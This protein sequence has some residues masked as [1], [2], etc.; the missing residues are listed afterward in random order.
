MRKA[1]I[2]DG[3]VINVVEVDPDHVP[4]WCRD[5]P[6][7]DQNAAP[8]ATYER[9]RFT[10]SGNPS[11]SRPLARSEAKLSRAE[12][13]VRVKRAGIL[14][15]AQAKAAARG[16]LPEPFR[17]AIVAAGVDGDEAEIIWASV[18]HIERNHPFIVALARLPSIGD[19]VADAIF[20]I[21]I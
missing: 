4:D 15:A 13:L 14:T 8:G 1:E 17:G 19:D 9:G 10:R 5:W 6:D 11:K 20:G 18:A 3:V 2:K 16:D 12:F 21:P 7:A